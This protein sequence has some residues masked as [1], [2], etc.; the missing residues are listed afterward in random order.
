MN[1]N[2]SCQEQAPSPDPAAVQRGRRAPPARRA[3]RTRVTCA[4]CVRPPRGPYGPGRSPCCD[5]LLPSFCKAHPFS[6]FAKHWIPFTSLQEL[7]TGVTIN[8]CSAVTRVLHP[9]SAPWR[10]C[11]SLNAPLEQLVGGG[12]CVFEAVAGA[13]G[14]L[15]GGPCMPALG[16]K[17]ACASSGVCCPLS[18]RARKAY[19]EVDVRCE[20]QHCLRA[21]HPTL[22]HL[23]CHQRVSSGSGGYPVHVDYSISAA[24]G[25]CAARHPLT[26][27]GWKFGSFV[28]STGAE[29][30]GGVGSPRDA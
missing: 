11:F 10:L 9:R 23:W 30:A 5:T 21:P 20:A 27:S 13:G 15:S 14:R 12:L 19:D 4:A 29:E 3:A 24:G 7:Q 2:H 25:T 16:S 1:D 6:E 8:K 17:G 28:P 18:P 26:H 22:Y